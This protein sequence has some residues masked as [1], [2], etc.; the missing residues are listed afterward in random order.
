VD[1]GPAILK[2]VAGERARQVYRLR[3]PA[4]MERILVACGTAAVAAAVAMGPE[5]VR[6]VRGSWVGDFVVGAAGAMTGGLD[7]LLLGVSSLSHLG[8][9]TRLVQTLSEA[10]RTVVHTSAEPLMGLALLGLAVTG[11]LGFTV[12]RLG[13]G[14]RG[15]GLPHAHLLA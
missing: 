15:G 11:L 13:R 8:W 6:S 10:T 5:L 3:L 1:L 14:I 9:V 12:L 7:A 4:P 2:R